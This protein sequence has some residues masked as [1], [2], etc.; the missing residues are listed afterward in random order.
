MT[1]TIRSYLQVFAHTDSLS[2]SVCAESLRVHLE[3][4][5]FWKPDMTF[6]LWGKVSLR[7]SQR[8]V[9]QMISA[10]NMWPRPKVMT[11][12]RAQKNPSRFSLWLV[13]W[14][15]T[16]FLN[17][18]LV[19]KGPVCFFIRIFGCQMHVLR[20]CNLKMG[21]GIETLH[22]IMS[23][24][25]PRGSG[26]SYLTWVIRPCFI[27]LVAYKWQT[28]WHVANIN[29]DSCKIVLQVLQ[30]WPLSNLDRIVWAVICKFTA[31]GH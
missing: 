14:M 9:G 13:K 25:Y 29:K 4:D 28:N 22:P 27:P 7:L 5:V 19:F 21:K 3:F 18:A 30:K 1:K 26:F 10:S 11:G 24:V 2:P 12:H 8:S 20:L 17:P 6:S 23:Y 15:L 16:Y 31:Q